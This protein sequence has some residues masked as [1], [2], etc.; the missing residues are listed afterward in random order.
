M[1]LLY[2][3]IMRGVKN[4][5]EKDVKDLNIGINIEEFRLKIAFVLVLNILDLRI[6][7]HKNNLQNLLT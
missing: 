7:Y 5:T 1:K 3:F 4:M 2:I 6:S